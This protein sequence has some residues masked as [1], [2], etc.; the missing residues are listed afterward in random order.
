[1]VIE[2]KQECQLPPAYAPLFHF[3]KVA[4]LKDVKD[5]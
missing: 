5:E 2:K 4:V 3:G 1:M